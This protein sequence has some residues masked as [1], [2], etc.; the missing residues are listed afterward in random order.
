MCTYSRQHHQAATKQQTTAHQTT[1]SARMTSSEC[2]A[3]MSAHLYC[4]AVACSRLKSILAFQSCKQWICQHMY[5][6]TSKPNFLERS[7]FL[8]PLPLGSQPTVTESDQ[9]LKSLV[10]Y[11]WISTPSGTGGAGGAGEWCKCCCCCCWLVFAVDNGFRYGS[12]GRPTCAREEG[13]R[14][15]SDQDPK[16]REN[17]KRYIKGGKK[18]NGL[19]HQ[20]NPQNKNCC[21]AKQVWRGHSKIYRIHPPHC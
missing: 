2:V 14:L 8:S 20:N 11:R 16:G 12:P 5:V 19:A 7:S 6:C 18:N 13:R 9:V 17:W 10:V 15:G 21:S 4:N 1:A 3:I